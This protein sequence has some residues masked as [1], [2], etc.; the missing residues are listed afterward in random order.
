MNKRD[1][2]EL[3]KLINEKY[4][5]EI[6][7]EDFILK[8]DS[9]TKNIYRSNDFYII[10]QSKIFS[11]ID[12][13]YRPSYVIDVGANVGSSILFSKRFLKI[14]KIFSIEPNPNLLEIIKEN[15]IK[16]NINN[17][18]IY[19]NIIGE[20]NLKYT[21]FQINNTLSVDSRVQGLEKE[22]FEI[23]DHKIEEMTLDHLIS[24]NKINR[25]QSIFIKID[26]QGYERH[27]INGCREVL[28][29][30]NQY[31][32]FMEFA[33][34]W[35]ENCDTD[36]IEFLNSLCSKYNV[37][38]IPSSPSFFIDDIDIIQSKLIKSQDIKYFVEYVRKLHKKQ[39]GWCDLMIFKDY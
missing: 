29:N 38:E 16:N 33:P 28:D 22:F 23:K 26:T 12:E 27:V 20:N 9:T 1:I 31:C 4:P 5:D 25:D 21:N 11:L 37:C 32:I 13:K 34:Y 10:S 3:Y 15:F 36:P 17:Y 2:S 24:L 35:L 8:V 19:N 30:F 7:F 18:C 39:R 14:K 6:E